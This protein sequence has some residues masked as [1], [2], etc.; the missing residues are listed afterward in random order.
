MSGWRLLTL[1]SIEPSHSGHLACP[2]THSIPLFSSTF[3][4]IIMI[5]SKIWGIEFRSTLAQFPFRQR[6]KSGSG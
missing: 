5:G 1:C 2:Q 6:A 3:A 4:T